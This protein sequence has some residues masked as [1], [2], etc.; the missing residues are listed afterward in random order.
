MESEV[1]IIVPYISEVVQFCL[2]VCFFI[3]FYF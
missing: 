2:E 3:L 1:S